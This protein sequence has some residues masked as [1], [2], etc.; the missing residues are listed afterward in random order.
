M[1][2]CF[3]PS[4]PLSRSPFSPPSFSIAPLLLISQHLSSFFFAFPP[5]LGLISHL[6]CF[7]SPPLSLSLSLHAHLSILLLAS[8]FSSSHLSL[9]HR[10]SALSLNLSSPPCLP[11][12]PSPCPPFMASRSPSYTSLS[13]PCLDL[14]TLSFTLFISSLYPVS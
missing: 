13:S 11:V 5:S 8:R 14:V 9:S 6:A 3:P 12:H 7:L 4:L 2:K 10:P 1:F